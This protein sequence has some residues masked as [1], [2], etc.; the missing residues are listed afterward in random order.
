[1]LTYADG[2]PLL[3]ADAAYLAIQLR[4]VEQAR[5]KY[6]RV[7][8]DTAFHELCQAE[9]SY[10]NTWLR[11]CGADCPD[12]DEGIVVIHD[13]APADTADAPTVGTC[14]RCHGRGKIDPTKGD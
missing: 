8:T 13:D 12:C 11:Y 4:R 6:D 1:V 9:N 2:N 7:E 3:S 10:R 5:A 14:A